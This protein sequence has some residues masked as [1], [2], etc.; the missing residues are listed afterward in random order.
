[1]KYFNRSFRT[2]LIVDA[3]PVRQGEVLTQVTAHG[4]TNIIA[5]A[6]RSLT[7]RESRYRQTEREALAVVWGI[8]HFHL[9]LYGSSFKV[10]ADHKPSETIFNNPTCKATAR[11]ERLQLRLQPCKTKIIY[12]PGADNPADYM[13]RHTDPKQSQNFSHLSR[14]DAYINFVT[15][16]VVPPAVTLQ[17]V[18][19]ATAADETLQNLARVITNQRWHEVG[20]D[21]SQY[22]QIKLELS[23][24]NGVI[25]RGTR[26]VVPEKLQSQ[27]VMLAHSGH[28]GIVKTKRFLRES[29]WFPGIDKKV[30]ELVKGCVPCQATNHDPK[31]A[32]ESL[33][34]S[35]LPQGPS[36]ELSMDFCGP[37]PNG[38]YL[39]VVTD[40]F[41]WFPEVEIL[42]STSAKAVIPHLDSILA[43]QG[44]AELV[45]IDNGPPFNSES[46]QIF[47]IQL[48]FKHR[49]ITPVWPRANGEAERFMKTLEKAVRTIVIQ[50]KN[51]RQE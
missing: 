3:S 45:R 35:P 24:S 18:K 19:D 48:G 28:Q 42:R 13:T 14:V 33:Q 29:V 10:I 22:Q 47:A 1:M 51:W 20:K 9:Y 50:G 11:L 38:D 27:M 16:Y 31:P 41:S 40:D 32:S 12:K 6:S 23:I 46:F 7:D 37:F 2:E 26:I 30:E 5:Y 44:I 39:L 43:R 15:T 17:E 36:Q 4:G 25:L 8:E 21:V 49:R 34:M